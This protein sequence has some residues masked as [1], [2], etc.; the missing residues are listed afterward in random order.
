MPRPILISMIL[1]AVTLTGC[2]SGPRFDTKEYDRR[3]TPQ[4]AVQQAEAAQGK[5][6]LWGGM[7][8]S[9][10]NLDKGS[11]V[12]VLAYPLASSQRPDTRRAPLGRFIVKT[13]EYL[14]S[15]DY[16]QGRLLTIAG[17]LTGTREGLVG[18]AR[19]VY[20]V[21]ESEAGRIYLWPAGSGRGTE[22]QFSIGV[23]VLFGH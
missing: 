17:P 5:R 18:E 13:E 11:E 1:A 12:E 3:L 9:T 23:G 14:E 15:V 6:V 2:A 16:G 21:V 8:I 10:H 4:Q 7:I 20:P 19:Y 22:P